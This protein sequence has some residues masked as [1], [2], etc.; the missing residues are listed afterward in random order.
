MTKPT[1]APHRDCLNPPAMETS[2]P[3]QCTVVRRVA[4]ISC[5]DEKLEYAAPAKELYC[6]QLFQM[7]RRYVEKKYDLWLILSGE[8]NVLLPDEVVAP[9]NRRAPSNLFGKLGWGIR[10]GLKL[11][12]LLPEPCHIDIFAGADYVDAVIRDLQDAGHA[13]NAPMAGLQVGERLNWLKR[14]LNNCT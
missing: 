2:L 8:H 14:Q 1:A 6:S 13:V 7:T 3:T 9:Y 10:T 4:L 11:D 5:S 12:R